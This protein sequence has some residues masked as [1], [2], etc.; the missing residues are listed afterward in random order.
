MNG[1]YF[2]TLTL[3]AGPMGITASDV[4]QDLFTKDVASILKRKINETK[5]AL[6]CSIY[7]LERQRE[8]FAV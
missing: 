4:Q 2:S 1:R 5:K 7:F 3:I 8:Q 6:K